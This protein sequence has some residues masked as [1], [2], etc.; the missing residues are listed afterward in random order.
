MKHVIFICI[1]FPLLLLSA[2]GSSQITP[3]ATST[4]TSLPTNTPIPSPTATPTPSV[5][6]IDVDGIQVPDPKASN[7]ELFDL[8]NPDSPIVQ[9]ANAFGIKPEDVV[10]GLHAELD[11]PA[12]S[13][14]PFSV[15][16]TNDG[17]ALMMATQENG[18]WKWQEAT[19][20]EYWFAQGKEMG[21]YMNSMQFTPPNE[22]ALGKFFSEGIIALNRQVLPSSNR[23][24][25]QANTVSS[26][27]QK[28][29]MN[30]FFHFVAEPG[31]FPPDVN[32]QNIDPWLDS[33]FDGIINLIKNHSTDNHP[34]YVSFNEAW[35]GNQWNQ[36][37]NPI[38]DKYGDRWVEEYTY[39]LLS[40]FIYAELVPNKDFV[41]VFNDSGLYDNQYKQDLIYKVLSDARS[42]A[43]ERLMSDPNM[44]QRLNVIGINKPE[45]IQ[46]LLGVE[47]HLF[48]D[49]SIPKK[50]DNKINSFFN[51]PDDKQIRQ[52][53]DRFQGLGGI[54]LTEV[55]PY[56]TLEEKQTFLKMI[57]SILSDDQNLKG[58][59]FWNIFPDSDLGRLDLL[60][61]GQ[62]DYQYDL[63]V[64]DLFDSN[65]NP[66]ALYYSLLTH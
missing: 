24:P 62:S 58:A 18:Q 51:A 12:S 66:A 64:L 5:P 22:A 6:M 21:A 63:E 43:F 37:S 17:I 34:M 50:Y 3:T 41:I 60:Q 52:L 33:R 56:G 45:D 32:T 55:N 54:I 53:A 15:L 42:N 27:A 14:A 4:A 61:Q 38:K 2:C 9:F 26:E 29:N 35:E 13:N 1:L 8:K 20:G 49:P 23:T 46:M 30:L 28:N 36:D 57:S 39:K 16:R 19:P 44:K 59:I 65:G 48:L 10:S 11:T 47:N 40:K 31:R 7:P 25:D